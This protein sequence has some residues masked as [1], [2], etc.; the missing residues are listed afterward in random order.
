MWSCGHWWID[1]WS[2]ARRVIVALRDQAWLTASDSCGRTSVP[3]H[4]AA[5]EEP[6]AIVVEVPKAMADPPDLLDD[7]ITASVGPFD[8]PVVW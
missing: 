5:Q 4:A 8:S 7:Q 1:V 6:E 3:S 2:I